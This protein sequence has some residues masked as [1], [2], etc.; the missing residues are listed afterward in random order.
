[1][2]TC[3]HIYSW[4]GQEIMISFLHDGYSWQEIADGEGY[5]YPLLIEQASKVNILLN[6]NDSIKS[7][8]TRTFSSEVKIIQAICPGLFPVRGGFSPWAATS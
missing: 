5:T 6:W 7:Q 8:H 2:D 4:T 1:M 3:L